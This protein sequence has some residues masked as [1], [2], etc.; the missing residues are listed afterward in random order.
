MKKTLSI[1]ISFIMLFSFNF[2][3]LALAESTEATVYTSVEYLEDGSYIETVITEETPSFS[4]F[5]TTTIKLGSKRTTYITSDGE[6]EWSATINGTFEY[7]GFNCSCTDSSITYSITNTKWK[8]ISATA[9]KSY[10]KAIGDVTA[11][12]YVL[13]VPTKTIDRTITLTCSATGVLS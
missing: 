1:I 7:T 12:Y 3:T 2:N 6:T 10:N 4:P 13:G 8:M 11:K 5:I 9:S